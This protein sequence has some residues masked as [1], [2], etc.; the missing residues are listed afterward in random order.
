MK[1]TIVHETKFT[2]CEEKW[3][4]IFSLNIGMAALFTGAPCNGNFREYGIEHRNKR[5]NPVTKTQQMKKTI[6]TE[7]KSSNHIV[8]KESLYIWHTLSL[9]QNNPISI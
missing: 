3:L 1:M 8:K 6:A 2:S 4:Q 7:M 9:F 5:T